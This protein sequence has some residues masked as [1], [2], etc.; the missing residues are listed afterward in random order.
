MGVRANGEGI[1]AASEFPV[2]GRRAGVNGAWRRLT[3]TISVAVVCSEV[4]DERREG[5]KDETPADEE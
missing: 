4:A 5:A 1:L 3:K 2:N